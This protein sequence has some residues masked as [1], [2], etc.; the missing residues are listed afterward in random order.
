MEIIVITDTQTIED[1]RDASM[2]IRV[3][4]SFATDAEFA[5]W[6][7][8]HPR[9][10]QRV[11][12]KEDGFLPWVDAAGIRTDVYKVAIYTERLCP[13][14]HVDSL[15]RY[16]FEGPFAGEYYGVTC[17]DEF[18]GVG[19]LFIVSADFTKSRH[20][21]YTDSLPALWAH[22]RDGSP[23]RKT[24]RA[25]VGTRGTR[26]VAGLGCP[27]WIAFDGGEWPRAVPAPASPLPPSWGPGR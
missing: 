24:D 6:L 2:R 5:S 17:V 22:L 3:P 21:D 26:A 11:A 4:R 25:G 9:V 1:I 23:V 8:A 7:N 10:W 14:E 12:P 16:F 27:V 18:L 13:T 15:C 20:D 19:R